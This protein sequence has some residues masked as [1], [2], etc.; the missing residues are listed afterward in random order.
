MRM[1]T[2]VYFFSGHGVERRRITLSRLVR[3]LELATVGSLKEECFQAAL[4]SW[5]GTHQ[6]Q[7]C[8]QLVLRLRCSDGEPPL[9]EF[10][11][12][13]G[14]DIIAVGR[15]SVSRPRWDIGDCSQHISQVEWRMADH[16]FV[17]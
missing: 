13:P 15:S 16:H 14:D 7:F 4:E 2:V 12:G 11:T 9:T 6:L 1:Y 3:S 10:Q 5:R 8:W 17:H